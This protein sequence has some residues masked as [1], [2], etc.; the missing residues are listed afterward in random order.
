LRRSI[1]AL[2]L[3]GA[4]ILLAPLHQ[5]CAGGPASGPATALDSLEAVEVDR[6]FLKFRQKIQAG[7]A[8]SLPRDLSRESLRWME[9]IRHASRTEPVDYLKDRPFHEILCILALR[10]ERRLD[11]AFDDR[12][13]GILDRILIANAPIK[14]AFLKSELAPA[15][16]RGLEG[17]I[18]L[19]EAPRVPVFLFSKEGGLWRF[20]LVRSLPLILQGAETL[21]RQRKPTRLE[22]AIFL[23]DEFG[24]SRVLPEDLAR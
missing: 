16:V 23:L 18:G 5:G 21:A 8:D 10:V 13:V 20:H 7:Q 15:E 19:R 11:P 24:R 3:L 6:F 14:R 4:G 12:P 1:A 9:D 22:Q 17:G 2:I